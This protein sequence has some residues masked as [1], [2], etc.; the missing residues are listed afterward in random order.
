MMSAD[1]EERRS[2]RFVRRVTEQCL[3]D[4]GQRAALRRGLR[5]PPEQAHTM[6]AVV[7]PLLPPSVRQDHEYA[8][9]A[10]AAMIAASVRDGSNAGSAKEETSDVDDVEVVAAADVDAGPGNRPDLGQSLAWAVCR[11][12]SGRRAMNRA[13][14]EKRLH[15]LVRQG[16]PGVYQHLAGVVR[17]LGAVEVQVNWGQLLDDLCQWR[18][19]RDH[20]AKRWLQSYYRTLHEAD[21]RAEQH[22]LSLEESA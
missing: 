13:T 15:L 6:H 5:R 4:R 11:P 18:Y 19:R 20:V 1:T 3:R 21:R 16:Y 7:A 9:Y 22:H 2:D 17:H 8:Y 10:V 14:A 12:G